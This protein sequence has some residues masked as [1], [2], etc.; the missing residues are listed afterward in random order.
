MLEKKEAPA[1]A[2]RRPGTGRA[3]A[4]KEIS[5]NHATSAS[6]SQELNEIRQETEAAAEDER[7][8]FAPDHKTPLTPDKTQVAMRLAIEPEAPTVLLYYKN[9]PFLTGGIVGEIAAQG[10]TGKGFFMLGGAYCWAK[11]KNYGPLKP[12]HP[13]SILYIGAEDPPAELDRRLWAVGGGDYPSSLYAVSMAGV[14]GPL[15]YLKGNEP[16]RSHWWQWLRDTISNHH[17]DLLILDPKSRIYGLDENNADHATQWIACLEALAVEFNIT[18][19]FAHHVSKASSDKNLSQ[20]MSRG[21]SA[22]ADGCRWMLG[23]EQMNPTTAK[24]YGIDNPKQY[25]CIDLVKSNYAAQLPAPMYFKRTEGGVLV[26]AALEADRLENMAIEMIEA[27]RNQEKAFTRRQLRQDKAGKPVI[28]AL[29]EV[30]GKF[31]RH[32]EIDALVD[33]AIDQGW[34]REKQSGQQIKLEV[35][36]AD[37][38]DF[39]Q[40]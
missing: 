28:D 12:A 6:G 16:K 33:Y 9:D 32:R 17:I 19:L 11:G 7:A 39:N 29:K 31:D 1:G 13:L 27:L 38:F 24:R 5:C 40:K 20:H 34:L 37:A 10:G 21:S 3:E 2:E 23:M 36:E 18:I 14:I 15:M 30:Y 22:I 4:E 26:Y 35:Q 8:K 25:I